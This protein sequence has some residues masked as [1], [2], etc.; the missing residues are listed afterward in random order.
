MKRSSDN[1][2]TDK[3]SALVLECK[4]VQSVWLPNH[5]KVVTPMSGVKVEKMLSPESQS[6]VSIDA[7]VPIIVA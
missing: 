3:E 5:I 1:V 6:L 7:I 4:V 2:Q